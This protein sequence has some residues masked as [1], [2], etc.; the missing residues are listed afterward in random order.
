MIA[1]RTL[2]RMAGVGL[3]CDLREFPEGKMPSEAWLQKVE[4]AIAAPITWRTGP[5]RDPSVAE[6]NERFARELRL[7]ETARASNPNAP[8]LTK[9][10]ERLA[11]EHSACDPDGYSVERVFAEAGRGLDADIANELGRRLEAK[12][13]GKDLAKRQR[14]RRIA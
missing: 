12:A 5:T 4:A 10:A 14:K 2:Q 3:T 6:R 9:T 1:A 13:A 8:S 11:E 7:A